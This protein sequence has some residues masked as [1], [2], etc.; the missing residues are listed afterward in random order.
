MKGLSYYLNQ[1]YKMQDKIVLVN[2]KNPS[3]N[4]SDRC[5]FLD[6]NYS[7][8]KPYNHRS[9][10]NNEVVIEFDYDDA[11]FNASM[12]RRVVERLAV[13]KIV[14]AKW[15]SGNKSTHLHMFIDVGDC[16]N[17]PLLKNVTMR[18]YGTFYKTADGT[19]HN[20][21]PDGVEY[22]KILPDLRL[23]APNHLIRAENGLHESSGKKKTLLTTYGNYPKVNPVA[24]EIWAMYVRQQKFNA[25]RALMSSQ[26]NDELK[27]KMKIILDTT[28]FR[29]YNDGRERA[30]FLLIH[31][32]KETYK[33]K[34]ADLVT[35]LS[36][37]YKYSSG[38]KL[39]RSDI[40]RKVSYQWNRTYR[41]DH[42]VDE[43]LESVGAT[44]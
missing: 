5:F 44:K 19:I 25:T 4:W 13:D 17:V 20:N 43:L 36:D 41:I 14:Y 15:K 31:Y 33:D 18:Y 11:D 29:N 12:I 24:E 7:A 26:N 22:T 10:L 21:K 30:L 1:Y 34:Q 39:T 16:G 23:A 9:I 32:L 27:K 8:H 40:E 2:R 35:Y 6:D 28:E 38:T 37:W 3:D 42:M